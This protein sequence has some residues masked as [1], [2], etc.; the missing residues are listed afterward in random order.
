MRDISFSKHYLTVAVIASLLFGS[1]LFSK[2]L[3]EHLPKIMGDSLPTKIT[4]D[5][6]EPVYSDGVLST[7]KGGVIYGSNLRI[8]AMRIRYVRHF[9]CAEPESYVDAEGLLIVEYGP[10]MFIGSRLHYDFASSYGIIYNGRMGFLPWF[11]GGNRIELLPDGTFRV[12]EAFVTTSEREP[13]EWGIYADEVTVDPDK[14][15]VARAVN[16]RLSDQKLIWL[17]TLKS[18]LN[19]IFD[20]PIKYRFRWGGKQGPRLG[21]TYEVF[22]WEGWKTYVRFDYRVTRGPGGGVET[23][24]NSKDGRTIFH[25]TNYLSR[26]SA[27]IKPHEKARFRFE[28]M[29]QK[30]FENNKTNILVTYDKISDRDVPGNYYDRDFEFDTSE[31]TQLLVR[32]QE[33][34]WISHFYCRLRVNSFQTVK[35]ELPT[36]SVNFKPYE[37]WKTGILFTNYAS[38][39]FLDFKYSKHIRHYHNY[40]STRFEYSPLFYR[41][42]GLGVVT[43]TPK[44]GGYTICYGS[45]P[46]HSSRWVTVGI[47]GLE[48]QTQ[49]YRFY[50]SFKHVIEPYVS[51][52]YYSYPLTNPSKHYIFDISDGW[53]RLSEL[54]FGFRNNIFFKKASG[55]VKRFIAFDL[56]SYAFFDQHTMLQNIPKAYSRFVFST[57]PSLRHTIDFVWNIEHDQVDQFNFRTDFTLNENFAVAAEYRHRDAYC[58]RKV[59]PA[60]FFLDVY[61]TERRLLHS[62]LSDRR[63]TLLVHFFYR[64]HPN[65]ACE[66]TSRQG[67]NRRTQPYYGE[68]ELN[69]FTTIQTA[70]HVVISLQHQEDENRAAVFLN[71]GLNRPDKLRTGTTC[72]YFE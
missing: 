52:N 51:Y 11:F 64:F 26:D 28:G 70:W 9:D 6:R 38:V 67:W 45:S 2:G 42:F 44:A 41:P 50:K 27:I 30:A 63:D 56:Y 31:R 19:A 58:W 5:L 69:F 36:F 24:Y 48:A 66:F 72:S 61:H 21:F 3:E 20:S 43:V 22:D 16:L 49:L 54:E 25:S 10:Y 59:D 39:A 65:W 33:E 23:F 29:Y 40:Q 57:L 60:N 55:E 14:N 71:V 12:N 53:A 17:P 37:L 15:L 4:A 18:N 1:D 8:Q 32:H 46:Q 47:L 62:T 7:D 13:P 34:E 35:E 68:Y